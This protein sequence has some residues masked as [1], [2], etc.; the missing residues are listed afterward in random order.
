V[1]QINSF[2][3]MHLTL[4][5]AD[6]ADVAGI[7]M[8]FKTFFQNSVLFLKK[9]FNSNLPA[10]TATNPTDRI[11]TGFARFQTCYKSCYKLLQMHLFLLQPT[12]NHDSLSFITEYSS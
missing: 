12:A 3:I 6:V 1:L 10:T 7:S 2:T 8:L 11:T 5:V 9:N 4:F